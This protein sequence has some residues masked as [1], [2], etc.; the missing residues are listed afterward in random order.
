M[1]P[2]QLS[3]QQRETAAGVY[4]HNARMYSAD[5]GRFPQADTVVPDT[6]DPQALN[7]YSY[8]R[9]SPA[10]YTDP[11]EKHENAK[12]NPVLMRTPAT[13]L[14]PLPPRTSGRMSLH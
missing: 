4:H 14:M 13:G 12:R 11:T 1:T 5:T 9:N 10:M 7:R 2:W 3:G 8:V 6:T